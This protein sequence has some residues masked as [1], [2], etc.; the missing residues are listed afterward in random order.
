LTRAA[1]VD[2]SAPMAGDWLLWAFLIGGLLAIGSEVFHAT[3]TALF[4]GLSALVVAGLVGTGLITGLG[5]AV[6]VW[7][8]MSVV[9]ALPL[10]PIVK[11][12]LPGERRHDKSNED[13]DA[14]GLIVD[15]LEPVLEG[16]IRG[17]IR[18]QGTTWPAVC[19]DGSIPA[20]GKARLVM[21]QKLAW[22]VE[23]LDMLAAADVV[24]AA[25]AQKANAD[26]P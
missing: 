17:R 19:I 22:V 7:G 8:I 26:K 4:L 5:P 15:V 12:L 20:G 14:V 16:E 23:P 9:L 24:P 6:L 10:R 1:I 13:D 18:H 2:E 3:L 11:R 25:P 21:R